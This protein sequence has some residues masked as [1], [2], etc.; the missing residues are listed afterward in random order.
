MQVE[1]IDDSTFGLLKAQL[2]KKLRN[3]WPHLH[4]TL[5]ATPKKILLESE[6]FPDFKEEAILFAEQTG[7]R[8]YK[9]KFPA[10]KKDEFIR[11][12]TFSVKK[13]SF[14]LA[15]KVGGR[16]FRAEIL[17]SNKNENSTKVN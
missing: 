3:E 11:C 16:Y 10:L 1:K 14:N 13:Q 6:N 5:L 2:E 7:G 9:G 4:I 17:L 8:K 15:F 12:W